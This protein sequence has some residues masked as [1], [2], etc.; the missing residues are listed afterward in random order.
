M[1][2]AE[3]KDEKK[4]R[5]IAALITLVICVA[6]FLILLFIKIITPLPPFPEMAGGGGEELNFGIYNEGT[7]NVEGPGIGEVTSVVAQNSSPSKAEEAPTK[8]EDF[9]N[10]EQVN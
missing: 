2:I 1:I 9:K 4:D 3:K 7:G 6:L 10:G 8:E 5:A